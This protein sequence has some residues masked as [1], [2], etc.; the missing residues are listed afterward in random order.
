MFANRTW[1]MVLQLTFSNSGDATTTVI[2]LARLTATLNRFL[3]YRNSKF[4]GMSLALELVYDTKTIGLM[5]PIPNLQLGPMLRA[6]N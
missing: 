4:R 1:L 6:S 5:L 3:L 2:A